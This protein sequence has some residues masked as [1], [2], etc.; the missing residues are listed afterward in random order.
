MSQAR[1]ARWYVCVDSDGTRSLWW[2]EAS[3]H[4]API[5]AANGDVTWWLIGG[6]SIGHPALLDALWPQAA[7]ALGTYREVKPPQRLRVVRG[8]K[9]R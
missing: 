1:D 4:P 2:G 3:H 7:I 8:G 6:W 9:G 5:R